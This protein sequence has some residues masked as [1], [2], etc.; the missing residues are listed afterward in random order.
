MARRKLFYFPEQKWKLQGT[1]LRSLTGRAEPTPTWPYPQGRVDTEFGGGACFG[2][3]LKNQIYKCKGNR[4]NYPPE[5]QTSIPVAPVYFSLISPNPNTHPHL[6]PEEPKLSCL[7]TSV[8]ISTQQ[9]GQKLS[10]AL[11]SSKRSGTYHWSPRFLATCLGQVYTP[12]P[13]HLQLILPNPPGPLSLQRVGEASVPAGLSASATDPPH[14]LLPSAPSLQQ[15]QLTGLLGRGSCPLAK[16]KEHCTLTAAP[17]QARLPGVSGSHVGP[18]NGC[19]SAF[20]SCACAHPST[21]FPPL[22]A[23]LARQRCERSLLPARHQAP[24]FLGPQPL[25]W[26]SGSVGRGPLARRAENTMGRSGLSRRLKQ[27]APTEPCL[28]QDQDCSVF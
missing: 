11:S 19:L 7:L 23:L 5:L 2:W 25:V 4:V 20:S 22:C 8:F 15:L 17:M 24:G 28:P 3:N 18:K 26:G 16:E 12:T 14:G 9:E 6:T 13:T 27:L 1:S 10:F 21:V